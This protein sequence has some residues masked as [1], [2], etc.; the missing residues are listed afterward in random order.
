M[1]GPASTETSDAA[2]FAARCDAW[3][4][5]YPERAAALRVLVAR[6]L[7]A[8]LGAKAVYGSQTGERT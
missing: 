1:T 5:K 3:R 6:L 7:G 2:A 8:P 4:Q